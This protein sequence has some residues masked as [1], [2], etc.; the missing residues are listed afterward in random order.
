M[1][2]CMIESKMSSELITALG[3]TD[4]EREKSR[5]LVVGYEDGAWELLIRYTGSLEQI[6]EELGLQVEELL[7]GFAVIRIREYLIGR[8]SEYPQIDYIEKPKSLLLSEMEGIVSSCVSRV[9]LP[10]YALTGRGTLVACLD[11][12]EFVKMVSGWQKACIYQGF[13]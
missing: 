7:G 13:G 9:R 8:L 12:G 10:D 5:E 4:E 3:V 11:S 1:E 2:D 6:R